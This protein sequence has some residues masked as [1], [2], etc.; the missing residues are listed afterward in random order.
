ME[1]ILKETMVKAVVIKTIAAA[2]VTDPVALIF[3]DEWM[4]LF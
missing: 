2:W 4:S 3:T 1:S